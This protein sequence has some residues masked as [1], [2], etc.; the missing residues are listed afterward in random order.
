MSRHENVEG[1][2]ATRFR[3]LP[4]PQEGTAATNQP[5]MEGCRMRLP[6]QDDSP[7]PGANGMVV[8]PLPQGT[9]CSLEVDSS[10]HLIPP[11]TVASPARIDP[12]LLEAVQAPTRP[13]S[14]RVELT[15]VMIEVPTNSIAAPAM[16][17]D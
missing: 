17:E 2:M 16:N 11:N 6:R 14:P 12:M 8:Q 4:S 10:L 5:V 7:S 13:L 15:D 1:L 9:S 3:R